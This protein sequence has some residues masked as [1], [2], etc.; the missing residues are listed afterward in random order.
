MSSFDV[1]ILVGPNDKNIIAQQLQ[2]TRKNVTGFRNIYLVCFDTGI[3]I[4]TDDFIDIDTIIIDERIF[5]FNHDD[6]FCYIGPSTR[7][8][9][10]FQQLIKLYCGL[11]I[12]G[13]LGT[14]LIIDADTFFLKPTTF[15]NDDNQWL[16]TP[17]NEYHTP[18][19]DHMKQLHPSLKR[20]I[21]SVSGISHH[22]VF[23]TEYIKDL[24]LM[25]CQYHNT[26]DFWRIFLSCI[27]PMYR[28]LSGGSEYEIY[29]NYVT[30]YKSGYKIR[31]LEWENVSSHPNTFT[32]S[33][34]SYV[35]WHFHIR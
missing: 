12:P 11:I 16:F 3:D 32:D 33:Q 5:P 30:Q 34:L 28:S 23:K 15:V 18:Y 35:S 22:M 25:V 7:N 14:Y 19:F 13:I 29:F 17:S 1:V 9:W 8:C 31:E 24:F 2:Y 20:E 6:I 26:N 10:Y 27:D 4:D 21:P